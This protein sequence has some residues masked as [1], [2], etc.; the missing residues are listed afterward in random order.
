[1]H[2]DLQDLQ[3]KLSMLAS[4]S[5]QKEKLFLDVPFSVEEVEC[6]LQKKMKLK[7][8]SGPDD[9]T[10]EH[11]R[12]GGPTV[13]IW[14]TKVLNSIVELEQIPVPLMVYELE[15]AGLYLN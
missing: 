10:I 1:M 12:Y 11:L 15:L 5:L 14:L 3:Q 9:L 4:A 6:T 13:A 7:K 8:A 2:A